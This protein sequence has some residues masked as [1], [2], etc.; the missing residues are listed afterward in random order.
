MFNLSISSLK[1]KINW[2]DVRFKT[3]PRQSV[4]TIREKPAASVR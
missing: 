2:S 1:E 4:L 3:I